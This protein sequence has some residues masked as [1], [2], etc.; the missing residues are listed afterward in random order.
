MA[1]SKEGGLKGGLWSA[2][3]GKS[4]EEQEQT[5]KDAQR[6]LEGK[7]HRKDATPEA[8]AVA[9][10]KEGGSRQKEEPKS[11]QKQLEYARK[12]NSDNR[13]VPMQCPGCNSRLGN[14]STFSRYLVAHLASPGNGACVDFYR[15]AGN[16]DSQV[17][18]AELYARVMK[19]E[20]D[21]LQAAMTKW[22]AEQKKK[23]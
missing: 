21:V 1:G 19:P 22:R 20:S 11:S 18:E 2:L 12:K 5:R 15:K 9:A 14:K 6:I 13:A 7:L 3:K 10:S 8:R 17:S 23:K 4:A 16:H